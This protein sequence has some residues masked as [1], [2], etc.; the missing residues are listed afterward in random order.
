MVFISHIFLPGYLTNIYVSVQVFWY[1]ISCFWVRVTEVPKETVNSKA[2][3]YIPRSLNIQQHHCENVRFHIKYTFP[4]HSLYLPN[5]S[6]SFL[7]VLRFSQR[8]N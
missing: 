4:L 1:V 8:C 2:W 6:D 5:Q 7:E 3:R